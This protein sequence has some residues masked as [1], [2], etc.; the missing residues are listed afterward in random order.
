MNASYWPKHH[1]AKCKLILKGDEE[2]VRV[3]V[4][5]WGRVTAPRRVPLRISAPCSPL[6]IPLHQACVSVALLGSCHHHRGLISTPALLCGVWPPTPSTGSPGCQG[7]HPLPPTSKTLLLLSPASFPSSRSPGTHT[8]PSA[9][10]SLQVNSH[11][12]RHSIPFLQWQFPNP[13]IKSYHHVLTVPLSPGF[14]CGPVA[15]P[16]PVASL[17]LF[18]PTPSFTG[19]LELTCP[20]FVSFYPLAVSLCSQH[21]CGAPSQSLGGQTATHLSC[22]PQGSGHTAPSVLWTHHVPSHLRAFACAV[23]CG[24]KVFSSF[25]TKLTPNTH[26][27]SA[28]TSLFQGSLFL[29]RPCPSHSGLVPGDSFFLYLHFSCEWMKVAMVQAKDD[30]A[31]MMELPR[32]RSGGRRWCQCLRIHDVSS[33]EPRKED[34]KKPWSPDP[35]TLRLHGAKKFLEEEEKCGW[36]GRIF[37][38]TTPCT[39][40]MGTEEKWR[41]ECLHLPPH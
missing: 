28:Q 11:R 7:L 27:D 32:G 35:P 25:F 5:T 19:E 1:I 40:Y 29:A 18:P 20:G 37:T 16:P 30:S 23:S 15:G 31:W 9:L 10:L 12:H 3:R 41:H 33:S 17:L 4:V 34:S 8:A 38:S 21:K 6:S 24:Q 14:C 2:L 39:W 36:L 13:V 26:L 22:P